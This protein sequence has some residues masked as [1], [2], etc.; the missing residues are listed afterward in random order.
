MSVVG[1]KLPLGADGTREKKHNIT[2]G[3]E[4]LNMQL[5][6]PFVKLGASFLRP[7][8]KFSTTNFKS[9]EMDV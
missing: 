7:G 2:S 3:D 9:L 4:A 5:L 8:R 1:S 6:V